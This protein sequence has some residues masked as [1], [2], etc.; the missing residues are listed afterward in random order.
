MW[1]ALI[2]GIRKGKKILKVAKFMGLTGG[3]L[4]CSGGVSFFILLELSDP[5]PYAPIA[6]L[7][8]LWAIFNG[9]IGIIGGF[10]TRS[11]P[12]AAGILLIIVSVNCLP[13]SFSEVTHLVNNLGV[14]W[15][16]LSGGTWSG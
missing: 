16:R 10:I 5:I 8:A 13:F 1:P 6:V 11:H 14:G 3:I 2:I 12:L 9:V 4:L 7:G 15:S